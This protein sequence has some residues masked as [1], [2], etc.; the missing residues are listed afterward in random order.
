VI[1]TNPVAGG[2]G[3]Y[4]WN[5]SSF[6]QMPGGGDRIAVDPDGNA[7]VTNSSFQIYRWT[8]S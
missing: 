3:I 1:G 7:W 2:Y 8:S 6:Q 5:G 4:R